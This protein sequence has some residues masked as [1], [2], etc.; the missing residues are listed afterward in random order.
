MPMLSSKVESSWAC[1]ETGRNWLIY[2]ALL[3]CKS[4]SMLLDYTELNCAWDMWDVFRGSWGPNYFH[5]NAKTARRGITSQLILWCQHYLDTKTRW[6]YYR[7]ATHNIPQ[8]RGFKNSKQNCSKYNL[9]MFKRG[10]APWPSLSQEWKVAW[11]FENQK[12]TKKE[13]NI[14]SLSVNIKKA[15][16]RIQCP[17]LIKNSQ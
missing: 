2:V 16:D 8:E 9:V 12:Q 17:F 13:I 15:F 1:T 4:E 10:K 11:P 14:Q 7:K 6:R 3:V 5:N